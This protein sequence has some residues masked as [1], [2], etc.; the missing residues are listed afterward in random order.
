[1]KTG[2]LVS[3]ILQLAVLSEQPEA[4]QNS[5]QQVPT[6]SIGFNGGQGNGLSLVDFAVGKTKLA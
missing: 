6:G 3:G 5:S 1:M 2:G 4:S